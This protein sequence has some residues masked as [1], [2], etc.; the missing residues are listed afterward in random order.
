MKKSIFREII[1]QDARY[2]FNI[3][4]LNVILNESTT[5]FKGIT[6]EQEQREIQT[7]IEQEL[8][9]DFKLGGHADYD[10]LLEEVKE[11]HDFEEKRKQDIKLCSLFVDLRNFTRR[12]L[13]VDDPGVETIEEIA[14]LKQEAISTWIKLAR[15]Y[16]GH[17]H[18][19]TGDGIMVL[20][21]GEQDH[22]QDEWTVGARAFLMAIRILESA[23]YLNEKLIQFLKDKGK[24]TYAQADNLL[25]IKVGIEYSPKTLINPQGVIVNLSEQKKAIGEVK[26]TS[27]EVDFSAKLLSYYKNAKDAIDGSPKYGRVLLIGDR[28][29]ELMDFKDDVQVIKIGTYEKSMYNVKKSHNGHYIDCKTYKNKIVNIEDVAGICNVYDG[30]EAAKVATFN[31]LRGEEKVQHG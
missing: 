15:Y 22:D 20:L 29:K 26:A 19:I 10:Y 28:Y 2:K 30:S 1:R 18:S 5:V 13:F 16:Q 25:D 24:E 3:N 4:P 17:I 9:E 6:S 27:F 14:N 8:T 7:I 23:D 11:Y 21:G 31:I 12:A